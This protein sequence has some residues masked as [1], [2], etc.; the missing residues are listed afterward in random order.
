MPGAKEETW[1]KTVH[2][3]PDPWMKHDGRSESKWS[4]GTVL[5]DTKT[6]I[7]AAKRTAKVR[8]REQRPTA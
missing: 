3:R 1:A 7:L 4:G 5:S 8:K 6:S 2:D